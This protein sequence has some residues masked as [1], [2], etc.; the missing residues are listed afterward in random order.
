[1]HVSLNKAETRFI[2]T[3]K[4]EKDE[5]IKEFAEEVSSL[6]PK[7]HQ[8]LMHRRCVDWINFEHEEIPSP[9]NSESNKV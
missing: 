8:K 3:I 5:V 1:V 9:E 6:G 4:N 7:F 2:A